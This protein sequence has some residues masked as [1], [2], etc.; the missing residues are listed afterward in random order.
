MKHNPS[1]IYFLKNFWKSQNDV[2]VYCNCFSSILLM[3]LASPILFEEN[4]MHY[5]FHCSLFLT[6]VGLMSSSKTNIL[7]SRHFVTSKIGMYVSSPVMILEG[8]ALHR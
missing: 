6:S 8:G 3:A 1:Y 2:P 4:V 7:I 5:F